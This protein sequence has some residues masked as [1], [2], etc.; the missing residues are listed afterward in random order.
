MGVAKKTRKFGQVKRVIGQRDARLKANEEKA[1]LEAKAKAKRKTVNGELVRE[2][3]QMPSN[4]FF[5]HN[6]ALVPP[7]N[8][9][10]DTNFLSHTV[11]RKL[12]MLESMMDCLYA[13]CNP[14]ITSCVMAELEKLGPK[15]RLALRVARDERWQRLEC[16]HKGVY[17]DDCLVDR[18]TKNRIYIVGTN[19]RALKQRLRKIPGVP[20]MSVARGKYPASMVD[21][22]TRVLLSCAPCRASKLKCDRAQPCSQCAKRGRNDLCMYA[23]RPEARK[24]PVVKGM[25]ARLKRLEGMVRNMMDGEETS[26]RVLQQQ[27]AP[28][29]MGHMVRGERGTTYVGATHCMA[30]LEDI[31][32]LKTYFDD[33]EDEDEGASPTDELDGP[34]MLLWT[35]GGPGSRDEL[36]ARLPERHV[37]DRLVNRY[38]S[39]M[40]L[41]QRESASHVMSADGT[42]ST[43]ISS[44][45]QPLG[46]LQVPLT[47]ELSF[48]NM[49]QYARFWQDPSSVSLHWMSQLF[50]VLALGAY[51]DN[52][53]TPHEAEADSPLPVHDRVKSYRSCAG[54]A[55][56]L[57]KYTQPS[58]TT[59][60]A[61]LLYVEA[62]LLID[63][64]AQM[65]CYV[66][67]G[68]CLRLM[69]KMGLHRDPSKM[70][71]VSPFEGEMR[72]RMW[73][74]AVQIETLVAFHMGLPSMLQGVETDMTIPRNLQ[75]E[76]FDEDS[77][78]LPPGR[79]ETDYTH[80]SYPIHKTRLLGVFGKIARQAHAL[81]PPSYAEV[82][83]LD[84]LLQETWKGVPAFMAA[85]PLEESVGD[86]PILIIQRFGL[87]AIYNK[88]RCVLHRRYL[89]EP[90]P[91]REHDYSRKQCLDG[92]LTLLNHQ[93]IIWKA[94]MPGKVLSQNG[95]LVSSLVIHDLLLAAVVVY[96][97]IQNEHYS[98]PG[99][100]QYWM[101][102][103][104]A[105]PTKDELKDMIKCSHAIWYDMAAER[106]EL[107]KTV[108]I[109]ASI[110]AK[111]GTHV[112]SGA[113]V[114]RTMANLSTASSGHEAPT[115]WPWA[116]KSSAGVSSN[117]SDP[118]SNIG[119]DGKEA[120]PDGTDN[121][122]LANLALG[123]GSGSGSGLTPFSLDQQPNVAPDMNMLGPD[124]TGEA[125][126][127][128][129]DF[130]A[131]WMSLSNLDWRYLDISLADSHAAGTTAEFTQTWMERLP[132]DGLDMMGLAAWNQPP[133]G[134][135]TYIM[136]PPPGL[137]GIS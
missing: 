45:G 61:F 137:M 81:T 90:V 67:S 33:G 10:V 58:A 65:N 74:M 62:H 83:K 11:Q 110:L 122:P 76:D 53:A 126:L 112:G 103:Q 39:S 86:A 48:S 71:S 32:D 14:I 30:M 12:S 120:P 25:S 99:G 70:A 57:G 94:C 69:F 41:T 134:D 73:N 54:W 3:P 79:P 22:R 113:N 20:L 104:G 9:L 136:P 31:E 127:N 59:L 26:G 4:M 51:F 97:V 123:S 42:D 66:L 35:K 118:M 38:F 121:L 119:L 15:Y 28:I 135:G 124:A 95:W 102:Q 16:D 49:F 6:T 96:L 117:E 88:C 91:N 27:E 77:T 13:K 87:A 24:K 107:R 52:F 7:Y 5:Q 1:E 82:L 114:S 47:R 98:E 132:L 34:E 85:R 78:F 128:T 80:M 115:S 37:A 116:P 84:S 108:G 36:L 40:N 56:V 109:L 60:P 133:E 46:E 101:N 19:D 106:E 23:P 55:L 8:V 44:T 125:P 29:V 92:A 130:D 43:Q 18:V 21:K 75:D 2:A 100:E 93:K 129:V 89:A 63:R 105:M 131:P 17:A 50:M 111:I 64:A 68:V 72:R